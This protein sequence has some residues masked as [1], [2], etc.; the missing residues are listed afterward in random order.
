M[1]EEKWI[2]RR[3]PELSLKVA[4]RFGIEPVTA[5]ILLNRGLNSI[6][7]IREYLYGGTECFHD[8][9]LLK[10]MD[11]A[12][13]VLQKKISEQAKIRIVGDYDIDGIM[14]SYILKR[15]LRELGAEADIRIPHRISDGYGMNLTMIDEAVRDGID[16]IITCDNG[17]SASDVAEYANEH[18]ITMVVTDHHDV[19]SIPHAEAVIDPKR[20]DDAYPN[21]NICGAGVAWKLIRALG[22]DPQMRML[23][24]VGF[25]TVGDVVDLTGENRIFVR[26]GLRQLRDTDNTG[27][28]R[29]AE[30]CGC[31]LGKIDTYHIGFV[32]GP[33]M[34]ASGRLDSAMRALELLECESDQRARDLAEDLKSLNESR[35]AMTVQAETEAVHMIENGEFGNDRVLVLYM[36]ALHESIAG[37]VA[38]RIREK[39]GK[40]VFILT[41][42]EEAVKGS[43]RS[44]EGYSMAGELQKVKSLLLRFGGHPMAAGLS[45]DFGNVERLREALNRECTLSDEDLVP[46]IRMDA[47]VPVA[48]ITEKLVSEMELLGPFGKG[49]PKP[50]FCEKNAFCEH[51]R[52]FGAQHN[53]MKMRIRSLTDPR[54]TDPGRPGF[55]PSLTGSQIDAV[56]FRDVD[57]LYRRVTDNP[58]VSIIYEAGFDE[59]MGERRIQAVIRHFR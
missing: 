47:L 58:V 48:E 2:Y 15:G 11:R 35:K 39:Y 59:Y 56:C 51:P 20:P 8:P 49:N 55:Q 50:L 44:I 54:D 36:P 37:I 33:C 31:S 52:L 18:G 6:R 53:F 13:A 16:T 27:L 5:A 38:G 24:Y 40:P 3:P 34:N 10:D 17:I 57:R 46:K 30:V 42:G 43:G 1:K 14:S 23:Q 7:E 41:K 32:L 29:L 26:E 22:G 25:A 9:F 21:K 19:V 28:R 45:L 4:E 12:C